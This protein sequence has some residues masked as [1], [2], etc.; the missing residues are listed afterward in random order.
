MLAEN[1]EERVRSALDTPYLLIDEEKLEQNIQRMARLARERGVSLRPHI[2]TH[3]M[4][5]LA[6]RQVAA[7]ASG[8]TVAKLD[9]AEKMAAAG[10]ADIFVA[11]PQANR[12]KAERAAA[13][14][15]STRLTVGVD[16]R[17][18]ALLLSN[19]ARSIGV[20][21]SVRLE[22]DTGLR[23]TG[24]P[25]DEAVELAQGA[26]ALE[27]LDLT[28]IYT[29]R[30]AVLSG[31]PTMDLHG[32]GVEEGKIMVWI[33]EE[34]RATG[35]EV[36]DVSLGSTPTAASA[37]T[38]AGITE[39]RPGTYVFY[40]RMQTRMG[41]CEEGNCAL[42]VVCTVVSRPSSGLAVID[43]GS[44]TFATDVQPGKPPLDLSGFGYIKGY[45][46]SVLERLTEEHG[47]I[48]LGEGERPEVGQTLEI[49]P[50]HACS[51]VNLHDAAYLKGPGT[52]L[53]KLRVEARGGIH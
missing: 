51:T 28:G 48:S 21:I 10:I 49:V 5:P 36:R 3:K 9:E 32:A 39:I 2:K 52:E 33:A 22:V 45:P 47:M 53:G 37:A 16:S 30:G 35:V 44:K 17:E 19:A 43:G 46:R 27:G 40:D 12:R 15:R 41:A 26:A 7:G 23:R 1:A 24:V 34:I 25:P 18:T 13:L 8:I 42:S 31:E 11:Y 29:Y 14:A 4:P 38:V 20:T 6:R 50:N